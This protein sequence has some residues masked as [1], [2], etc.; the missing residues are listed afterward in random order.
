PYQDIAGGFINGLLGGYG[1]DAFTLILAGLLVLVFVVQQWRG[2]L[3]KIKYLQ[4]VDSMW[5][6]WVKNLVVASVVMVFSWQLSNAR[7]L[8]VVLILLA[9]LILIYG[10]ISQRTIF[11][12]HIYAMGGNLQA[13]KLSG[14][15]TRRVNMLL[16]INMGLLSAVAGIVYSARSNSA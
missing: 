8:P 4:P 3:A 16:F 11:G 6:F 5:L 15:K 12:R 10:F 14:V 2:R 7:G 13:A 9:A 1:Y